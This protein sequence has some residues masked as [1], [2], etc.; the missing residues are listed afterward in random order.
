[1]TTKRF[2]R[3][4]LELMPL[5]WQTAY[6]NMTERERLFFLGSPRARNTLH[7]RILLSLAQSLIS[8]KRTTVLSRQ[9]LH[10]PTYLSQEDPL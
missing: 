10:D 1:M 5:V 3:L 8:D 2:T 6:K 7:A 4:I 9:L